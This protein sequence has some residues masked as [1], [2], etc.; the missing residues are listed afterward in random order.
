MVISH[1]G[2]PFCVHPERIVA[3]LHQSFSHHNGSG[4]LQRQIIWQRS[5][6]HAFHNNEAAPAP[7][8]PS[9]SVKHPPSMKRGGGSP[10]CGEAAGSH[11]C[12]CRQAE[13]RKYELMGGCGQRFLQESEGESGLPDVGQMCTCW[14]LGQAENA[15]PRLH[16]RNCEFK[17]RGGFADD[18]R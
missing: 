16:E 15:K 3:Q 10:V 2:A 8:P 12:L 17:K 9:A 18:W 1:P 11:R 13:E 14:G 4:C 7:F 5:G 6:R